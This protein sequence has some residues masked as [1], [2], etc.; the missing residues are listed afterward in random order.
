MSTSV[1]PKAKAIVAAIIAIVAAIVTVVFGVRALQTPTP[2]AAASSVSSAPLP[3]PPPPFQGPRGQ[4]EARLLLAELPELKAW[5]AH[6]DKMSSGTVHGELV[7][8]SPMPKEIEGK[9]YW[10]FSYVEILPDAARRWETFLVGEDTPDILVDDLDT[11]AVLSLEKWRT[12]KKPLHRIAPPTPT[13]AA[14][15][16]QPAAPATH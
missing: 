7:R 13:P 8:F 9:H 3:P 10:Q 11:G 1:S 2:A 14:T 5:S 16:A 6:L 15:L 12:E 4:E